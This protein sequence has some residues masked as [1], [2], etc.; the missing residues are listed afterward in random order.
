[1][2]PIFKYVS[3]FLLFLPFSMQ[4]QISYSK[5]S[6]YYHQGIQALLEKD[7]LTAEKFFK[8]SVNENSDAESLYE[9]ANIYFKQN[10]IYKRVEARRLLNEAVLK[11]PANIKYKYLMAEILNR[12]SDGLAYDVYK[13][14]IKIDSTQPKALY[15]LGKIK[16]KDFDEY[17]DSYFKA[18]EVV[19]LGYENFA[20]EDFEN[21]KKYLTKAIKYD[22]SLSDAYLQLSYLYEDNGEPAK[23]I[24]LLK[25]LE[26]L[27]PDNTDAHL[28]LGLLFYEDNKIDSAF[29]EYQKA[30]KL[31]TDSERVDFTFKSVKEL[32]KPI[33]GDVFKKYS[34]EELH[35]LINEFWK[36]ND[37]LYLTDY[38]ERLLEHY[39]RVAYANLR[40]TVKYKNLPGWETD[41]GETIIRYGMPLKKVRYRPTINAGGRTEI[42]MK[43]DVWYYKYFTLGFTDQFMNGNFVYS[44][45]MAGSRFISQFG[46]DTPMLIEYLRKDYF[47]DYTPKFA[48]P[49]ITVPY[50]IVQLKDENYN[51]TDVYVNYGLAAIDSLKQGDIYNYKHEWGLFFFDSVYNPIVQMK[52]EIL[53]FPDSH[54]INVDPDSTLL[55][56]SLK[57]TVYP[58]TGTLAFEIIRKFDKGVSSNHFKFKAKKFRPYDFGMSDIIL[59]SKVGKNNPSFAT[60]NRGNI[61]LLPN[62][63][64]TFSNNESLFIYYEIYNLKLDDKGFN[65]YEQKLVLE[66]EN[67]S[68]SLTRTVNSLLNIVGLGKKKEEVI[69]TTKYK[70][71]QKDPRMYFQMDMSSYQPGNYIVT[72]IVKDD[73]T[74]KE[75]SSKTTLHYK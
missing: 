45:P 67:K 3:I 8:E 60:I 33:L 61:G 64:C 10:S 13:E 41:R 40:Y 36:I 53:V 15:N 75:V 50:N 18:S 47:E 25:K 20:Q 63:T 44:E 19:S 31:M 9:L 59:A 26:T 12:I 71:Q 48:G 42:F 32:L 62:P 30:L 24:P 73:L 22:S 38:N 58:D 54:K 16:G 27:N 21:A 51:Y 69:V 14:I 23:G 55:V 11:E 57:M 5:D 17:H 4:A 2:R 68:S 28:Y 7:T 49:N 66:K 29:K 72:I 1:M 65:N 43:T 70:T 35:E 34:D 74:G 56:N 6:N 37:P 46:Y 39:S 52:K